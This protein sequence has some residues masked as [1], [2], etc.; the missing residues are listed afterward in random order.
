MLVVAY[1]A[2]TAAV[3]G[4]HRTCA[5]AAARCDHV[6]PDWLMSHTTPVSVALPDCYLAI[7][8]PEG[9]SMMRP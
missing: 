9:S 6:L 8:R 2:V 7:L 3:R 1:V 4:P 5:E